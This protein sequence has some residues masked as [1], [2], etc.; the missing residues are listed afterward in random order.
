[1]CISSSSRHVA[2]ILGSVVDQI[3]VYLFPL[4]A[5]ASSIP[6]YS[7]IVRYNLIENR[8]CSTRW[9]NFWA[10]VFP[11]FL[12]IPL[13]AVAL[14]NALVVVNMNCRRYVIGGC[15]G[16][17]TQLTQ[18]PQGNAVFNNVVNITSI[19]FQIPINLII[20]FAIYILAR[21]RYTE[22][23]LSIQGPELVQ[24]HQEPVRRCQ[25]SSFGGEGSFRV[26]LDV[27]VVGPNLMPRGTPVGSASWITRVPARAVSGCG[28]LSHPCCWLQ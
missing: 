14:E 10:V 1:M 23:Q 7:I 5:V 8:I 17:A 25:G 22:Q 12:A 18:H 3:T 15:V 19:A 24:S 28:L 6:I 13:T 20:P 2:T 11:W 4:I 9:A 21:R 26:D 27:D 16:A